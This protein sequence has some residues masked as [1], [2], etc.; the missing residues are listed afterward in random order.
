M[1][2]LNSVFISSFILFVLIACQSEPKME[3]EKHSDEEE[4][5]LEVRGDAVEKVRVPL[6]NLE[7]VETGLAILKET[8]AGVEIT[9]EGHHLPEGE[10]GFHIHEKG[11]C[12]AP[13]FESAGSHF[14]PTD[15][16]HGLENPDGPHAGDMENIVVKEDGTIEETIVNPHVTLEKGKPNSL[17]HE[18]GTTLMIHEDPDDQT[19][20][21]AGN[22]G[23]RIVCGVIDSGNR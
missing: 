15:Q 18:A 7:G 5:A 20:Q 14:N 11:L 1:R 8:K 16:Q 3:V 21:P 9:L 23:E 2:L 10:H 17:F 13:T 19:S 6:V 22:A 4:P 12:E